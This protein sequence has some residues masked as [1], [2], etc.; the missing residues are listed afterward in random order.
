MNAAGRAV[1]SFGSAV[2]GSIE[3]SLA[4]YTAAGR[5][6]TTTPTLTYDVSRWAEYGLPSDGFFARTLRV[7]EYRAFTSGREFGFGGKGVEGYPNGMGF[8]G[9]AEEARGLTT[10][11]GYRQ[12]LQ[13]SYNPQFVLEFQLRDPARLQN[14]IVAPYAEFVK[15][16][17]TGAGFAEFNYPGIGSNDIVNPR[18]RSLK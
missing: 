3:S 11:N 5:P 1:N 16:G 2:S 17:K 14:V 9:S 12:G 4:P 6:I 10:V 8:I 18:V 7:E 15:G 13:L